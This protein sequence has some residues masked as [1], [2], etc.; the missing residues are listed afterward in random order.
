MLVAGWG[1]LGAAVGNRMRDEGLDVLA[2]TRSETA[3][4]HAARLEGIKVLIG[5]ASDPA[6]I[7][8]AMAGVDHVLCAV[9][10]LLPVAA[11]AQP[12]EDAK[13]ALSPLLTILEQLRTEPS[14]WFTYISSGGT[15]YGN[16][17]RVPA[18]EADPT[19]PISAYGVSRRAGELYAEMYSRT[20][21]F[22]VQILRVSNVYGPGQSPD[23]SQGAVAVFLH[24]L[25]AGLPLAIV[26]DG[27]ALRDYVYV[28]D[29]ADV[30]TRIVADQLDVGTVNLGS[31]CGTTVLSLARELSE[32]IGVEPVLEFLPARSHDVLAITLDIARLRSF[33]DYAPIDL[34]RGLQLTW[35]HV[36]AGQ[37]LA[38]DRA[39]PP[40]P[41]VIQVDVEAHGLE[42]SGAAP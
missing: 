37:V 27:S 40:H 19:R 21:G 6:V 25:A 33:I 36:V 28:S 15:V 18:C 7:A 39:T 31:G 29:V 9:G 38:A 26:G 22:P 8:D 32:I 12:L 24:R 41:P 4:T 3:R 10:G 20:Y 2:L 11:A 30:V 34:H 13:A 23:R 14:A 1:F 42:Q 35:H 16:P 5:D 17:T